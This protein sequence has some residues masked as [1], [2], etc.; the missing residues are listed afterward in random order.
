M[1]L[2]LTQDG[3]GK[4]KLLK[5]TQDGTVKAKLLTLTPSVLLNLLCVWI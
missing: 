1:L 5:L 4:A 2:K 3:T